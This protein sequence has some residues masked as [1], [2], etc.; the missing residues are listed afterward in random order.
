MHVQA[1]A[2]DVTNRHDE[3]SVQAMTNM[4]WGAATLGF[5]DEVPNPFTR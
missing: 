4:V 5:F 3:Y 1:V 2:A